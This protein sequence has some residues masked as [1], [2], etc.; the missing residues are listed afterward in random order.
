LKTAPI[1]SAVASSPEQKSPGRSRSALIGIAACAVLA[2]A[3]YFAWQRFMVH[4]AVAPASPPK[5]TVATPTVKTAPPP[6]TATTPAAGSSAPAITPSETLN[7]LATVPANAI[8]KAQ[9][10][11]ATRRASGQTRIDAAL[12]GEEV[13]DRPLAPSASSPAKAAPPVSKSA[14][15]TTTVAPGLTA[16]TELEAGA[17][18]SPAFRALIANAKV[19]GVFQGSPSRAFINGRLTR[20]GEMVDNALGVVFTGIDAERR[21]LL[22]KDRTGAVVARKY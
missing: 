16:T 3:G 22:F 14:P 17:E 15:A 12:T 20:P 8:N 18:A 1:E 5:S 4:P 2:A 19:S 9:E 7:K 21:Q 11:I 13:P 6:A 10:A